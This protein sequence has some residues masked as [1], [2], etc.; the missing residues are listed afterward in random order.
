[1][2]ALKTDQSNSKPSTGKPLVDR[3]REQANSAPKGNA[4]SKKNPLVTVISAANAFKN[5]KK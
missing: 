5:A 3:T 4:P 1:M 2:P